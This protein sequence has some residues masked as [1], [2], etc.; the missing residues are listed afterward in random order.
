MIYYLDLI[1]CK[2]FQINSAIV[3]YIRRKWFTLFNYIWI[4]DYI[5]IINLANILLI[6]YIFNNDLFIAYNRKKIQKIIFYIIIKRY[7][8]FIIDKI[9]NIYKK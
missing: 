9:F 1:T 2:K 7:L 4:K 3:V 8:N 6:R 5:F